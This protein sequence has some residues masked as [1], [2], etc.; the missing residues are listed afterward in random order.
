M[1]VPCLA[2]KEDGVTKAVRLTETLRRELLRAGYVEGRDFH[3]VVDVPHPSLV[4][5]AFRKVKK[6][7]VEI[8]EEILAGIES[9]GLATRA[10]LK[11]IRDVLERAYGQ[12]PSQEV[13][14]RASLVAERKAV[15]SAVRRLYGITPVRS[16]ADVEAVGVR[17]LWKRL[18]ALSTDP[19]EGGDALDRLAKEA[20]AYAVRPERV[21][22]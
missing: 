4:E 10:D 19:G 16:L 3:C 5:E 22:L 17:P 20:L 14:D 13:E 11:R 7:L 18:Y 21:E 6:P 1:A 12:Y 9:Q 15:Y 2:V 8:L